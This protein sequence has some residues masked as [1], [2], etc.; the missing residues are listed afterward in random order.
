MNKKYFLLF[1]ILI[2]ALILFNIRVF[3]QKQI[4]DVSPNI[5]CN[6]KYLEKSEILWII[7]KFENKSISE[8]KN[9]CQEILN[10]NKTLGL[11]GIYHSHYKE[12]NQKISEKEF[13]E[14]IQI[15][16]DCFNQTPTMFKPPQLSISKENKELIENYNLTIKGKLNQFFHKVYHCEDLEKDSR[17][18]FPNWLINLI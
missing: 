1:I 18:M 10:L 2:L 14:A 7:P 17:G 13:Q 9:W 3:S 12:F 6:Q 11:H 15:F 5:K 16:E 8:N 4:D